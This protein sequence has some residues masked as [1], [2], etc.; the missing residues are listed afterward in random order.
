M[1]GVDQNTQNPIAI[2]EL[3]E[4]WSP[5]ADDLLLHDPDGP[6]ECVV[7]SGEIVAAGR[8]LE[9]V[10]TRLGRW[11]DGVHDCADRRNARVRLRPA[12]RNRCVEIAQDVST[13]LSGVAPNH[14]HFGTSVM[15]GE[16]V[17]YG[18]GEQPGPVPEVAAP[19]DQCWSPRVTVG[20]LDTGMD[21][22][23]WFARRPWFEE[24]PEV[25]DADDDSGQDRQAGHGT[26]VA[27]LV[28]RQA[29]G[30]VLRSV[31]VLSSLGFTDDL[32]V[33]DGLRTLR[34]TASKR[35]EAVDVVLLTSGCRTPDDVCPPILREEVAALGSSVLV[36]SAGNHRSQR[37]FWP[38]A[39][40]EV[41]GVA[42]SGPNGELAEFSN[43]G[44]WVDCAAPGVDVVSSYVRLVPA[45]RNGAVRSRG[46]ARGAVRGGAGEGRSY[47]YARWS[48]TSF[49]APQVAGEIANSLHRGDG[50][51]L[52]SKIASHSYPFEG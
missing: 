20:V 15:Y 2:S 34:S 19:P 40:P 23:P 12:E 9:S 37:P 43:S 1:S 28:L 42:A 21:A 41:V 11:V 26:F 25:L 27:G 10:V 8:S 17:M 48:G 31:P 24:V 51:A 33:A 16:P 45:V 5:Y 3:I 47:G 14:V 7:R 18:T 52:A 49:A 44:R 13:A 35:G 39:L 50:P 32:R 22:H 38:A 36:A 30:V 46:V 6:G 4:Q 29:P